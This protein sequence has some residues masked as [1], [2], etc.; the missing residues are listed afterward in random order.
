MQDLVCRMY[1]GYK[2]AAPSGVCARYALA[3]NADLSIVVAERCSPADLGAFEMGD[4]FPRAWAC[5]F[6][7]ILVKLTPETYWGW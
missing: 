6:V 4:S 7:Y 1:V 5:C 2:C 3:Y